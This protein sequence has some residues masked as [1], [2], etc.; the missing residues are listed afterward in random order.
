M[1]RFNYVKVV[2][3]DSDGNALA[4]PGAEI[5]PK[6]LAVLSDISMPGWTVCNLLGEIK[7]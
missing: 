1:N 3:G 5:V 7:Q 6:L 2:A 4:L